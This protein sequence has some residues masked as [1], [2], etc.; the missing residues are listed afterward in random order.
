MLAFVVFAAYSGDVIQNYFEVDQ[1][2]FKFLVEI[3][4][5]VWDGYIWDLHQQIIVYNF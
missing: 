5:N 1:L 4:F 2:L 3:F